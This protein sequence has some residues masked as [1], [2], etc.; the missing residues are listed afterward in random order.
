[1]DH[2][3]F[4]VASMQS[5]SVAGSGLE[6]DSIVPPAA[7]GPGFAEAYDRTTLWYDAVDHGH[8]I[9]LVCP[10]L[11]NLRRLLSP[12]ALEI[13]G[14]SARICRIRRFRRHDIVSLERP[15][16][17]QRLTV[18][19]GDWTASSGLSPDDSGIFAGLNASLHIS[20]NNR[21]DWI[22]D[23]ARFHIAEHGLEAMLVMDNAS[24]AYPPEAI[25]ETLSATGLKRAVV[26]KVP[27]PYGPVRSRTGGGGAKFLQPAMLNLARMRFLSRARAVL[28]ADIDELVWSRRGSIFD[29]AV[30]SPL[31]IVAFDGEWVNP[32]PERR[33]P[34][35]HAD[36]LH[37]EVGTSRC[38]TK[39]CIR[40][41]GWRKRLGWDVHRPESFPPLSSIRSRDFG[42]WHCRAITTNWK[43]Y[44]R[45]E[46]RY[47]SEPDPYA[48]ATLARLLPED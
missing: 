17:A 44:D 5:L 36:H 43:S 48:A 4:S 47:V 10:K 16:G 26:L 33:E 24:D 13:D 2:A 9:R 1:M 14:A 7:Q 37:P 35:R 20:R 25:L 27:Q 3:D 32:G 11:M 28:N 39:Y 19:D 42:Y 29:A 34:Y 6:R 21:L 45:L 15:A 41:D 30:K 22:A 12:G 18:R 8:R 31:G 46:P 40:P 23:W 38:P